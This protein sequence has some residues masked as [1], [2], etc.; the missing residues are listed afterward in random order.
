MI[1][2]TSSLWVAARNSRAYDPLVRESELCFGDWVF[3]RELG[4]FARF[5]DWD[6][7]HTIFSVSFCPLQNIVIWIEPEDSDQWVV[8]EPLRDVLTPW[9]VEDL[10]FNARTKE[11]GLFLGYSRDGGIRVLVNARH[12]DTRDIPKADAS[13]WILRTN[14]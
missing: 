14:V 7:T 5:N 11:R 1:D 6:L 4:I 12:A 3:N 2:P 9:E 8:R 13:E 10:I